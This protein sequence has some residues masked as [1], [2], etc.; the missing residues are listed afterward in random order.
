MKN[1]LIKTVMTPITDYVTVKKD[2]TL[3]DVFH[4]IENHKT[5]S[6]RKA[7]RDVIVVDQD[8]NFAGKITMIDIFRELEPNYKKLFKNPQES[9][10]TQD[11]YRDALKDYN[12]WR[13]PIKDLCERGGRIKVSQV[14]HVPDGSE[15]VQESDSLEKALHVYVMGEHQPLIV[16]DGENI[17]GILRFEDLYNVIHQQMLQCPI[18]A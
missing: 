7:H 4:N 18:S 8:G 1:I 12:L 15:F 17:T 2:D 10:L 5:D 13:E 3:F 6:G 16:K 11:F 9:I 14:M